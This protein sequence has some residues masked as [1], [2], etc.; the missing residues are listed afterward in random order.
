MTDTKSTDTRHGLRAGDTPLLGLPIVV[1]EGQGGTHRAKSHTLGIDVDATAEIGVGDD[2]LWHDREATVVEL[3]PPREEWLRTICELEF[4]D[5]GETVYVN[6][7]ELELITDVDGTRYF[8][9]APEDTAPLAAVTGVLDPDPVTVVIEPV[10]GPVVDPAE[11]VGLDD[12]VLADGLLEEHAGG[13]AVLISEALADDLDEEPD[14]EARR[15]LDWVAPRRG[16]RAWLRGSWL[17]LLWSL[18]VS[19]LGALLDAITAGFEEIGDSVGA[20]ARVFAKGLVVTVA[21]LVFAGVG[22]AWWL[23]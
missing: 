9:T 6:R 12:D 4:A 15:L 7:D 20:H 2:V 21:V 13:V 3:Y 23:Q 11:W 16:V 17:G 10:A 1:V 8:V 5:G 18:T 14:A 22:I 19:L